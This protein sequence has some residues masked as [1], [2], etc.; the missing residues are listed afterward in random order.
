MGRNTSTSQANC[1]FICHGSAI[2]LMGLATVGGILAGRDIWLSG[3]LWILVFSLH[4]NGR[5]KEERGC[6]KNREI[7]NIPFRSDM[8]KLNM[9]I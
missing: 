8:G 7:T 6:L 5:L 4:S 2:V 1:V 3:M 9:I